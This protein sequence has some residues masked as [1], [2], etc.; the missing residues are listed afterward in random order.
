MTLSG[1]LWFEWFLLINGLVCLLAWLY[2]GP[3]PK[4]TISTKHWACTQ[5]K[6][7]FRAQIRKTE[8]QLVECIFVLPFEPN[9]TARVSLNLN[10]LA[11]YFGSS[12]NILKTEPGSSLL[13]NRQAKSSQFFPSCLFSVWSWPRS[14]L[15]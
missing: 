13:T 2:P 12:C 14:V 4:G 10:D 3:H 6:H 15:Y 7:I 5:K 1:G 8:L 11:H 9:G